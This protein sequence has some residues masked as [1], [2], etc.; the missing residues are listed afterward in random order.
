MTTPQ[1]EA[2]RR[3]PKPPESPSRLGVHTVERFAFVAGANWQAER[4]WPLME[5][6][7]EYWGTRAQLIDSRELAHLSEWVA[8]ADELWAAAAA[9]D[10]EV[11]E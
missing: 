1:E 11:A 3:Y 5:A 9:L 10:E 7:R 8:A 6:V 2:E 4:L